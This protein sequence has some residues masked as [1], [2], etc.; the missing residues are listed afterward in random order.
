MKLID[1][2][3]PRYSDAFGCEVRSRAHLKQLEKRYGVVQCT[4]NDMERKISKQQD[5]ERESEA[6]LDAVDDEYRNSSQFAH[7]RRA[8]DSG[9]ATAHLDPERQKRAR[10]QMYNKYCK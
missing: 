8:V 7:W 4:E 6:R 9:A 10:D 3:Y 1:N 2:D 5:M